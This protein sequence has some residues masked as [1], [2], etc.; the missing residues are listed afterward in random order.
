[1][2]QKGIYSGE[3]A[4]CSH[5]KEKYDELLKAHQEF[6]KMLADGWQVTN[7]KKAK[8]PR[9]KRPRQ[10]RVKVFDR[11]V[12]IDY[13]TYLNKYQGFTVLVEIF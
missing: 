8:R 5:L 1:M 3:W 4:G 12:V 7:V 13:N 2:K 9:I 10:V 11:S 6:E